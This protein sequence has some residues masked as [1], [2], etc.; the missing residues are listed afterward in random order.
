MVVTWDLLSGKP[1]TSTWRTFILCCCLV[2]AVFFTA[3]QVSGEVF[4]NSFL[5]RLH[6]EPGDEV[7][8]RV[9]SRNGFENLGPVS[10]TCIVVLA[11]NVVRYEGFAVTLSA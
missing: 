7:A 3:H 2:L 8:H 6:G 9:A 5:V 4:T 1:S 11:D 10:V